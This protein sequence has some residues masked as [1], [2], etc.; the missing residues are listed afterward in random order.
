M[1]KYIL[2]GAGKCALKTIELLGREHIECLIDNDPD[3]WGTTFNEIPV[4]SLQSVLCSLKENSIVLAVSE[5]YQPEIKKQLEETHI[6]NYK[7]IRETQADITREK[8]I[9][10][11]DYIDI[12]RK[13]ISW[14]QKNTINNESIICHTRKPKGYPEVTGYFIP[15]LIRW[16]YRS[17]AVSYAKW[18][19]R[20]QREDGAWLDTD[21]KEPYVFDTAQIL[22][23]LIAVREI[24]PHVDGC[25]K[26]GCDWILN[27]MHE[28]GRLSTPST[29]AWGSKKMCSE[30]IHLYCLSPLVQASTL[31]KAPHYKEAAHRILEYYK[32]YYYDEIMN[33]NLLS[34]FYAYVMEAL[35]DMGETD[36]ALTAMEKIAALQKENG[37]VP[38]YRDVDWICT[39]GLFQFSLVWFRLGDIERGNKAFRYACKLQN[40]SG[41]WY[42]S[43]LSEDNAE[44]QNNYIPNSEVS[45][46]VKYFLDA[47]YYKNI[48]EF[49]SWSDTFLDEID[50]EDERYKIISRNLL[51][52]DSK[53]KILDVGCGKGR[54]LKYLLEDAPQNE[55]YAVDLSKKVMQHI[56]SEIII[57]KQGSLTCINYPDN[58]FDV[59]YT[60]EALEHA[61]D[62]ESALRELH[63][64]T[65]PGGK[66]IIIDKNR[67]EL[68]RMNICEWETWFNAEELKAL[69]EK[70]CSDVQIIDKI[71][72]NLK[73]EDKLFLAWIGTVS[74]NK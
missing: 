46:A 40:P 65:K 43:Y 22:K 23:G 62:I 1:K 29:K 52:Q 16:G 9:T 50:R 38:A 4:K 24:Y 53:L 15:T 55:Y 63:R 2:F 36:M 42:G 44:E 21:G 57:K 72:Y 3:K 28:S 68:G 7:T 10:R 26:K 12:Y 66:I 34:H 18:L 45:W 39:P 6:T 59:V 60:C 13:A 33:F 51:A 19:C 41:G 27:N 69:M 25:I 14:I 67:D 61:I 58:Y 35:L 70:Y 17:L 32:T 11:T 73:K 37:A 47:L 71:K 8:I 30:L 20:I 56:T 5:K 74:K 48:A 31:F 49:N 64:V 54:Y